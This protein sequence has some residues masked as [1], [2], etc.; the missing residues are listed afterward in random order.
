MSS[1]KLY[2]KGKLE[3][4]YSS[5]SLPMNFILARH[6]EDSRPSL[7]EVEIPPKTNFLGSKFPPNKLMLDST[8]VEVEV[9]VGVELGNR[10]EHMFVFY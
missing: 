5:V 10:V 4:F 1:S 8:Q 2:V 3:I 7:R 6:V 9:E